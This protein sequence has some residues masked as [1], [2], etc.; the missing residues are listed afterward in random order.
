MRR[1]DVDIA[2]LSQ[3]ARIEQTQTS[4][5]ACS[6][7]PPLRRAVQLIHS[8]VHSTMQRL[9]ALFFFL[10]AIIRL[11]TAKTRCIRL[12]RKDRARVVSWGWRG[13]RDQLRHGALPD[14]IAE[15]MGLVT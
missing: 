4:D 6:I 1:I 10:I 2:E 11:S 7:V 12:A 13:L 14:L 15:A 3:R 5:A 9:F 8:A